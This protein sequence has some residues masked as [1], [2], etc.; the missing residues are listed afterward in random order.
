MLR[1][2]D[3]CLKSWIQACRGG[4]KLTEVDSRSD[5]W[6]HD[7]RGGFNHPCGGMSLTALPLHPR[8]E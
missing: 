5:R 3:S 4:I 8:T 6:A 1:G 2:V 7:Q